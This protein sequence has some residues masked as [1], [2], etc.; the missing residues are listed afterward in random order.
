M[1]EI[2]WPCSSSR[3]IYPSTCSRDKRPTVLAVS[4]NK[5]R[6]HVKISNNLPFQG[7]FAKNRSRVH[8]LLK[9]L[10]LSRQRNRVSALR[11]V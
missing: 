2:E 1:L 4:Q 9:K 3:D 7:Y 6:Q 8:N 10:M 11:Q 5:Y